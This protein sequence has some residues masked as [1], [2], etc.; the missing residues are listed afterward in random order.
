MAWIFGIFTYIVTLLQVAISTP[1]GE[2]RGYPNYILRPLL[3]DNPQIP[4]KGW[5]H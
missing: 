1:E 3:T 5:P 4:E 2:S